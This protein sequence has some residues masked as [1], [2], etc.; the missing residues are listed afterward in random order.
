MTVL[1]ARGAELERDFSFGVVLGLFEP[2][3]SGAEE[4]RKP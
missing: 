1:H 3:L 4:E 2:L